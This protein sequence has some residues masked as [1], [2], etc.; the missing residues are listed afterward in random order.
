MAAFIINGKECNI[1]PLNVG[2]KGLC[3]LSS[4]N[5]NVAFLINFLSR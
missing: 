5:R 1:K 3:L 4:F 2:F